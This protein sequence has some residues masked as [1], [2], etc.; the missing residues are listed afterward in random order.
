MFAVGCIQSQR[1]HTNRCPVGVTTQDP[2]LQRALV[3]PDKADRVHG[4][5]KNTVHA[6]AEMIAAM[7]LDHTSEL[8]PDHVVKRV[9]MAE[10]KTFTEIYPFLTQHDLSGGKAPERFQR[11]WDS[12][13]SSTFKPNLE[14]VGSPS[15]KP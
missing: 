2:K 13:S 10:V 8:H 5:H 6:L 1:C 11:W 14:P 7:G 3:V 9:S 4:F 15:L 12:T